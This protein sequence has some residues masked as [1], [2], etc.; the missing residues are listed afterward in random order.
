MRVLIVQY[1]GD[2]RQ[3]AKDFAN[4]KEETYY[5]QKYSVNAVAEI[6]KKVEEVA[7][8]CCLTKVPYNEVLENGVRAIGTGFS[9]KIQSRKLLKLVEEYH[10]T[11]LILRTPNQ[12][13]IRWA[14]KRDI[15]ILM[16]LAD[17]FNSKGLRGKIKNYQLASLLNHKK[18]DWVGNHNITASM[19]LENIGVNPDKIISWDWPYQISPDFFPVKSLPSNKETWD[20]FYAGSVTEA[21]GIGDVIEAIAHLKNQGTSIQLKIAGKGDLENFKNKAKSLKIEDSIEFLGLVPNKTIVPL[22]READCVVVPSRSEYPEGFPMTI[23]EALYS[24]TPIIASD[25]SSKWSKET[26]AKRYVGDGRNCDPPINHTE[27]VKV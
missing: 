22:M 3:A 4:H 15:K 19:S 5:A 24:R 16:L 11:H 8:L 9:H 26:R 6:G 27:Y 18:I 17:S 25:H 23:N 10:P 12:A 7:T 13:L 14:I 20:V 2:Y 21:K 1:S